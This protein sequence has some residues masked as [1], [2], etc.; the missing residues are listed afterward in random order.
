MAGLPM[1]R[2]RVLAFGV[3][4]TADVTAGLA[5][6]QVDPLHAEL[7]ALLAAGNLSRRVEDL[8]RA[9]VRAGSH[10]PTIALTNAASARLTR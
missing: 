9:D 7:Q 4:A 1:V 10:A 2:G 6:T 5:H 3:V 8:E